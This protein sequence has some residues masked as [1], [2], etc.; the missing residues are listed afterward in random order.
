MKKVLVA[1]DNAVNRELLREL[2]CAD[3]PYWKRAMGR[4]LYKK[5]EE[6]QPDILLLD[7]GMPILDGYGVARKSGEI[8]S[9]LG[10]PS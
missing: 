9:W 4:K 2:K 3:T 6:T 5:I 7:L 1:E 8:H 10:C